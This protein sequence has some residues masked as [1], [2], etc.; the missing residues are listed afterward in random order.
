MKGCG[1]ARAGYIESNV[2]NAECAFL[3]LFSTTDDLP[4]VNRIGYT[5]HTAH[6]TTHNTRTTRE[7]KRT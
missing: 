3:N 5:A 4:H 7:P 1:G 2:M 6:G